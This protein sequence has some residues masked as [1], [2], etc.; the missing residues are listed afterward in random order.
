MH[1]G[2]VL[3]RHPNSR[4]LQIKNLGELNERGP[5]DHMLI[6]RLPDL[7]SKHP[8]M[9]THLL[10][11]FHQPNLLV[12]LQHVLFQVKLSDFPLQQQGDQSQERDRRRA[13]DQRRQEFK[14]CEP[15]HE[16]ER[17]RA[18]VSPGVEEVSHAA[19]DDEGDELDEDP[20]ER[21]VGEADEVEKLEGDGEVGDGDEE[22]THSLT[23]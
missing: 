14:D 22:I 1:L 17:V 6:K 11:P 9:N 16:L 4:V 15:E 13:G 18:V 8:D 20:F 3:V 5:Q 2:S 19:E 12:E 21:D 10:L 7:S 23:F